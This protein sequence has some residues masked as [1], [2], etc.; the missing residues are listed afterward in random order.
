MLAEN[1]YRLVPNSLRSTNLE[2][3]KHT[4]FLCTVIYLEY[5]SFH[6]SSLPL[7]STISEHSELLLLLLGA[8]LH[9]P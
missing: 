3:N 7:C 2:E 1:Y 5:P 9:L 8:F 6:G 4:L